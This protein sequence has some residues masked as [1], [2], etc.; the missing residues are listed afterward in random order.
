MFQNYP[1]FVWY[2]FGCK[3]ANKSN[4]Q[5][6]FAECV[7][8]VWRKSC[9]PC[10]YL[11]SKVSRAQM[12][13]SPRTTQYTTIVLQHKFYANEHY[14]KPQETN[15]LSQKFINLFLFHNFCG[16]PVVSFVEYTDNKFPCVRHPLSTKEI[17]EAT[18]FGIPFCVF[19]NRTPCHLFYL[20]FCIFS[21]TRVTGYGLWSFRDKHIHN[22][23][24]MA[25]DHVVRGPFGL[26]RE[27]LGL[28]VTIQARKNGDRNR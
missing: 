24:I 26:Y 21:R 6:Y 9:L 8:I 12:Q 13:I 18:L 23:T 2:E 11:Y 4:V 28:K 19:W 3:E 10:Q 22:R 14:R 1:A 15:N 27:K 20:P 25:E 17:P 16:L 7:Q 5:S